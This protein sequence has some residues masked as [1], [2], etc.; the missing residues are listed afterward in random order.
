MASVLHKHLVAA[1]STD[2]ENWRDETWEG[3]RKGQMGQA[4]DWR[5]GKDSLEPDAAVR[6]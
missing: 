6:F 5:E 4:R 3:G 1:N 2:L